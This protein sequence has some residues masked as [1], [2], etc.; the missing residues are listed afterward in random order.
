MNRQC[1][2]KKILVVK[3]RGLGDAVIG[4]SSVQF[5]RQSFPDAKIIY[6][7]PGWTA[8]L[9]QGPHTSADH[10]FALDLTSIKGYLSLFKELRNV[11]CVFELHQGG[12]TG[13]ALSIFS[14]LLGFSYFFHNHHQVL[15]CKFSSL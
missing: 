5:L 6:A 11:D 8:S 10:I 7:I 9:L 14:K 15:C 13:K 4:L 2:F 1:Q 3:N 12:K